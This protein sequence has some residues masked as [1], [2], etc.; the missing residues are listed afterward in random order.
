MNRLLI[1]FLVLLLSATTGCSRHP[2]SV[3]KAALAQAAPAAA[4]GAARRTL[5]YQHSIQIDTQE[6][7]VAA[8]HAAAL[9]ACR[10]AAADLCTVLESHGSTGRFASATLRLRARPAGIPKLIAALGRQADITEQ[11][12][13]AEDLAAPL[14]DGE[15]KLAMLTAYRAQLED[16]RHRAGTDVDALI[17][18]NRE[19]A[20]VQ[21][22][23]EAAAGKQAYLMQRVET[24]IL[25]ISI[26]SEHNQSFWR[27]ISHAASDFGGNLSQ[28]VSGAI[29]GVAYLLPWVL[30]VAFVAW[31][32]RRLWRWRRAR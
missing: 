8:I 3:D 5:A 12:T 23:L 20:Q 9:A 30:I 24:E 29:T 4:S 17:K 22:E 26:R 7:R 1:T 18:V 21:S 2:M 11:S 6:D 13:S 32:V 15:K 28:G 19:L 14:Q 25:D 16:L 31:V 10:E 27:P